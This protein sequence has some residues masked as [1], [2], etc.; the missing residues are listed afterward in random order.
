MITKMLNIKESNVIFPFF[1][2]YWY[3]KSLL[4]PEIWAI[5]FFKYVSLFAVGTGSSIEPKYLCIRLLAVSEITARATSY[6]WK[7]WQ[8]FFLFWT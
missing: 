4:T 8:V 7:I 6:Q 2:F 3:E 1:K 5:S